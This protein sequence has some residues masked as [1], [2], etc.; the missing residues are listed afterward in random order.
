MDPKLGIID[1][2]VLEPVDVPSKFSL[3]GDPV[4]MFP[5]FATDNVA[6][7][8]LSVRLELLAVLVSPPTARV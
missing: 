5:I 2:T 6:L 3:I 4:P 8:G 7:V 1:P